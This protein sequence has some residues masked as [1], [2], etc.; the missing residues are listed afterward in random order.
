MVVAVAAAAAAAAAAAPTEHV[1][2][3]FAAG[4]LCGVACQWRLAMHLSFVVGWLT[5]EEA[6][7]LDYA[8][9]ELEAAGVSDHVRQLLGHRSYNPTLIREPLVE[10]GEEVGGGGGLWLKNVRRIEDYEHLSAGDGTP[11]LRAP[12]A[13]EAVRGKL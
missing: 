10:D 9:A 12:V 11:R 4:G 5:P 13:A 3:W 8:T 6:S 7:P 1:P 2:C